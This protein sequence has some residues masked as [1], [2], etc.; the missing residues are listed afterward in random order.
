MYYK[1]QIKTVT[2]FYT[3]FD[4]ITWSHVNLNQYFVRIRSFNL[5]EIEDSTQKKQNDQNP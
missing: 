1:N 3:V 2:L 5:S 4:A